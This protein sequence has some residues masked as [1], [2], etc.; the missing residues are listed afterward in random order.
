MSATDIP[1]RIYG[2]ADSCGDARLL[3]LAGGG[4]T[5]TRSGRRAAPEQPGPP[6]PR[7]A[8]GTLQRLMESGWVEET[9]GPGTVPDERRSLS[10]SSDGFGRRSRRKSN[11]STRLFAGLARA[12][13]F[14]ELHGDRWLRNLSCDQPHLSTPGAIRPRC[15]CTHPRSDGSFRGKSSA[16]STRHATRPRWPAREAACGHSGRG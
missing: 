10:R 4:A 9:D 11:D 15:T 14:R 2:S 7:H 13:S 8:Y 1:S 5:A 12:A 3:S 16:C 6:R